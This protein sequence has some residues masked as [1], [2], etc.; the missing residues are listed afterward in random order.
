M[1][2]EEDILEPDEESKSKAYHF[3]GGNVS[4]ELKQLTDY[5]IAYHKLTNK[6]PNTMS[7][8]IR[9][10]LE[11]YLS[12]YEDQSYRKMADFLSYNPNDSSE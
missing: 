1:G 6:K 8:V 12:T 4:L 7:E 2:L 11:L 9:S 3:I 10:A 5:F